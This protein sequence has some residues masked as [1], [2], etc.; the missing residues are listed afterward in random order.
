M[1]K[2]IGGLVF[3]IGAFLWLGNVI[4]FFHTFTGAGW[5]GLTLGGILFRMGSNG[6]E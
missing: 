3:V 6:D 2:I 1:L 5:I 4:G